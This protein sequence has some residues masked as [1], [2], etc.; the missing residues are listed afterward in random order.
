MSGVAFELTDYEL[1][2]LVRKHPRT[3]QR[4]CVAGKLPGA[5]KAGR[6][7]R[8]PRRALQVAKLDAAARGDDLQ[9]E[10]RSAIL[11]C[12]QLRTELETLGKRRPGTRGP[13]PAA[14]RN[15]RLIGLDLTTL[16]S[17]L[18]GLSKLAFEAGRRFNA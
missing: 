5:Y 16:E 10:L 7:W 11:V 6:S 18:E 4:W 14:V 12:R 2:R 9:R 17:D 1:A 13:L 3:V 15:W 8:I